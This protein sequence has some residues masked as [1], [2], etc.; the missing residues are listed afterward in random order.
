MSRPRKL[1]HEDITAIR[2]GRATGTPVAV[3]ADMYDVHPQTIYRY[4]FDI[5]ETP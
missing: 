4:T 1:T 2:Q 5:Q 3:L